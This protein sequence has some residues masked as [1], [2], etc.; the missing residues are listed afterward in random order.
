MEQR[1]KLVWYDL[2]FERKQVIYCAIWNT[3][4]CIYPLAYITFYLITRRLQL[5]DFMLGT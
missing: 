3:V 5:D 4:F 1:H 2:S